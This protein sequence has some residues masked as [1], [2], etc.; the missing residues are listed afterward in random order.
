MIVSPQDSGARGL[1]VRGASLVIHDWPADGPTGEVAPL[2]VHH[3][4][5]EAWH[6]VSGALRSRV[7]TVGLPSGSS[8]MRRRGC[9][10][11][12]G[13][14]WGGVCFGAQGVGWLARG[15]WHGRGVPA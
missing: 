2:H 7:P 3:A 1:E 9:R 10:W 12:V 11:S 5:D 14:V 4:D 6:V 13:S 15:P 8:V